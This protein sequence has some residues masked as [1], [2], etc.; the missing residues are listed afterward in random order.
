MDL[1]SG[2]ESRFA[3]KEKKGMRRRG[4]CLKE[5]FRDL[6]KIFRQRKLGKSRDSEKTRRM[7]MGSLKAKEEFK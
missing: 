2:G 4:K 6:E 5:K 7:Q 3:K 1:M